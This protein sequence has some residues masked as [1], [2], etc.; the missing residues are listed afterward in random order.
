MKTAD[1]GT[2]NKGKRNEGGVIFSVAPFPTSSSLSF[3]L[4]LLQNTARCS[5]EMTY[6]TVVRSMYGTILQR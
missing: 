1:G 5:P 3:Q 4:L 2:K 6:R